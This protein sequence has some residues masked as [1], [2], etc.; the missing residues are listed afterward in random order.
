MKKVSVGIFIIIVF[1]VFGLWSS[2]KD[3]R[4]VITEIV[5]SASPDKV[6]NVLANIDEWK[7]WSPIIKDSEGKAAQGARLIITMISDEGKT[8]KP[9]PK[10]EPTI[11]IFKP[12]ENITWTASMGANFIMTNG[13]VLQLV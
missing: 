5:I 11:T 10:Y 4:V 3:T 6:W 8:G 12:F 9:G 1:V 2:G 7:N 13:K